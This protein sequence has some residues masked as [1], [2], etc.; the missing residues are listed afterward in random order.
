MK[1]D[2]EWFQEL[3]PKYKC[4]W[5]YLCDKCNHAGVWDVNFPLMQFVIKADFNR[6][7]VLSIF[8]EHIQELPPG[9]KWLIVDFVD[10]QYGPLNPEN[11]AHASVIEILKKEGAYKGLTRGKQGRKDMDKDKETKSF[12]FMAIWQKYP[13]RDG[14]KDAQ[15]HFVASVKTEKDWQDINTALDNYLKSDKV[16]KGFIKNG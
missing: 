1:W 14:K 16:Q 2:K 9:D 10:F 11:R 6:T 15:R 4:L 12:D 5:L 3:D 7:E 8:K 13:N